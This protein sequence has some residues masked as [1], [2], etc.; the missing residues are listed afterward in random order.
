M[1]Q[2][3]ANLATLVVLFVESAGS[4][5]ELGAF[6]LLEPINQKLLVAIEASLFDA[7]SFI[8]LGPVRAVSKKRKDYCVAVPW[9]GPGTQVFDANTVKGALPDISDKIVETLQRESAE[10]IFA[11]S[12][13]GHMML[14]ACQ[15]VSLFTICTIS[16]LFQFLKSVHSQL[17]LKRAKQYIFILEHLK[18]IRRTKYIDTEYLVCREDPRYISYGFR[19]DTST[20][21]PLRWRSMIIEEYEKSTSKRL[22]ALRNYEAQLVSTEAA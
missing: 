18:L 20:T 14:L 10:T 15:A 12:N 3:L 16:E 22:N 5:A 19:P 8:S 17:T 13:D 2:L 1:E 6:A 9:F 4:I 21:D 7:R 11:R